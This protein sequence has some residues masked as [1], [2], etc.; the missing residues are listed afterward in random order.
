[1][2]SDLIWCEYRTKREENTAQCRAKTWQTQANLEEFGTK[3]IRRSQT[4]DFGQN[5]CP[6]IFWRYAEFR[7]RF[8]TVFAKYFPG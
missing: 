5:I 7:R 2:V 1:M 8:G 6:S 4:P 3:L